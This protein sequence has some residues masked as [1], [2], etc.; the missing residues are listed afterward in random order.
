MEGAA[1]PKGLRGTADDPSVKTLLHS[2]W[3][4][5][6]KR[7]ALAAAVVA[8]LG[9]FAFAATREATTTGRAPS[10][11]LSRPETV[12]Q[13][14]AF[15][16]TEEAYIQALWPIHGEVERSAVH[17]SLGKIFIKSMRCGRR[18]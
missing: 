8:L 5:R 16:R 7:V 1:S 10:P 18:I 6:I 2:W 11:T 13:R 9:I 4:L 12:S 17:M 14:P 3:P 15:T